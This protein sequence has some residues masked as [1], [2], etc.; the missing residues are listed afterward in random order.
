MWVSG[1]LKFWDW[2]FKKKLAIILQIQITMR[3]PLTPT[4]M[5]IIK[6]S[7]DNKCW[8]ACAEKETSTL[9]VGRQIGANAIEDSM[10]F[11]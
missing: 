6:K 5:A 9:L 7:T 10:E 1:G 11:L 2:Q 4:R 3:Y 8:R